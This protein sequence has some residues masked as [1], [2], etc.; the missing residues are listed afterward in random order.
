MQYNRC[1]L[2]ENDGV[3]IDLLS[4]GVPKKHLKMSKKE[5]IN[6]SKKKDPSSYSYHPK[7]VL[8]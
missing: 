5:K 7:N 6:I 8:Y 2:L 3:V 1:V 4:F